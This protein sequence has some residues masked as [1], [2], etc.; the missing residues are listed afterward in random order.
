MKIIYLNSFLKDI[1]KV[2]DKKVK[3]KLKEVILELEKANSL[4]EVERVVKM[5]GFSVAYRI[6]IDSY[7]AGIYSYDKTVEMARF[8]KRNDIYKVFPNK[9]N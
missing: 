7:R 9:S 1:K 6:K 4:F 8:I 3:K 2:Q 5:Q